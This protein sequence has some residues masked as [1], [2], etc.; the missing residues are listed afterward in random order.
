MG[1]HDLVNIFSDKEVHIKNFPVLI[2][3]TPD[4]SERLK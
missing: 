2:Y 3:M 4:R 1:L